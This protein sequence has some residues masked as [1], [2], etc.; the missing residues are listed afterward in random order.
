MTIR[1]IR[2]FCGKMAQMC[3]AWENKYHDQI[4]KVIREMIFDR[5]FSNITEHE[6]KRDK[7]IFTGT[8]DKGHTI[9]VI[10][11]D[12][13][14]SIKHVRDLCE[15]REQEKIQS[16]IIV[17][18][19]KC[20]PTAKSLVSSYDWLWT[21]MPNELVRNVTHHELVPKHYL[22]KEEELSTM[23]DTFRIKN[24]DDIINKLPVIFTD[25]PVA[26]YFGFL[27]GQTVGVDIKTGHSEIRK[28]YCVVILP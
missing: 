11:I 3:P 13:K 24:R 2:L 23:M 20:T 19:H 17:S 16:L 8:D 9:Q 21:F 18:P 25:D 15:Y 22:V 27:H 4:L 28:L 6:I 12:Q 7:P 26:K 14:V 1:K 10:V 5:G